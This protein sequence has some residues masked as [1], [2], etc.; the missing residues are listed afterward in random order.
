LGVKLF[1]GQKVISWNIIVRQKG[2]KFWPWDWV[3][4][5]HDYTIFAVKNGVLTFTEK[6]RK[7]FD[8]RTY[9]ETY[10]SVV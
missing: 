2:N 7:R 3:S 4:Q 9:R 5:G 8:W 1:G 6:R 10:I